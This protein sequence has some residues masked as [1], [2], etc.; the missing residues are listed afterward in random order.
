MRITIGAPVD[1]VE[2]DV[3]LIHT[4]SYQLAEDALV[5]VLHNSVTH[6][7]EIYIAS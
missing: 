2:G 6:G 3:V 7:H 5:R 4:F 1:T